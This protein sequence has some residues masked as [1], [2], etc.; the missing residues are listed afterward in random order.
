MVLLKPE[1]SP[2]SNK[3]EDMK[4]VTLSKFNFRNC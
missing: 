3:Y 4:P 2:S 1:K